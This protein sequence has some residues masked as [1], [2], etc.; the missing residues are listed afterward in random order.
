MSRHKALKERLLS[1]IVVP[2]RQAAP[3]NVVSFLSNMKPILLDTFGDWLEVEDPMISLDDLTT[4]KKVARYKDALKRFIKD[5]QTV[6]KK[7]DDLCAFQ[8]AHILNLEYLPS[9]KSIWS[10]LL[11][12]MFL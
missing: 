7:I 1:P 9:K 10:K 11:Q 3:N 4:P 8:I 12:G 6:E 5:L 2:I